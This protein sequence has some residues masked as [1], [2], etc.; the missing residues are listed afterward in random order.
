MKKHK[1]VVSILL[2]I[3]MV[4]TFM[5]TL[6]F[7]DG[8]SV[9]AKAGHSWEKI[10]T[11]T[12]DYEGLKVLEAPTCET[13]GVGEITC[14]IDLNGEACG[15][16]KT[17]WIAPLGHKAGNRVRVKAAD[18]IDAIYPATQAAAVKKAWFDANPDG[19]C[20]AYVY[21]CDNCDQY[22]IEG[23]DG[24]YSRLLALTDIAD[25]DWLAH[26][27]PS[28]TAKCAETFTCKNC[29]VEKRTNLDAVPHTFKESV[30][31][32]H[33][34]GGLGSDG[35]PAEGAK[36]VQITT[37]K[38]SV[39]GLETSATSDNYEGA[40]I[41]HGATTQV[42]VPS[43]VPC[44]IPGRV[45]KVCNDCGMVT[46]TT[47][48]WLADHTYVTYGPYPEGDLLY[49]D[50]R[51]AV[52]GDVKANSKQIYGFAPSAAVA[53]YSYSAVAPANCEQGSWIKVTAKLGNVESS[54]VVD[55]VNIETLIANGSIV[56]I[57]DKYY[58]RNS[59]KEI[60]YVKALEHKF[61]D[62]TKVA[63][64][65]CEERGIEAKV[66]EKCG[67][68]D[69][70][71]VARTGKATGHQFEKT[72]QE[73]TCGAKGFEYEICSVCGKF[74]SYK[75]FGKPVVKFGAKCTMD[76][77]VV[78]T[79]ATPF[80]EGTK[81]LVCSVCGDDGHVYM[82]GGNLKE[83]NVTRTSI[84]K[85]KIAAPKVKAGKKKATVTVKAVEGA[86]K[87]QIKVN[88]KVKKTVTKAGKVT[89]KKLKG[90]KKAKF[91]IVA[92]DAEGTKAASKVKS[93]KIKK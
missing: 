70:N 64:P 32:A 9:A 19:K 27:E 77:W 37:Q 39:C 13:R 91:Q 52:C 15:A 38:C 21:K 65:T 11:V 66:C 51:C 23:G 75:E 18:L 2:A 72:T 48:N 69:H 34:V 22:I 46:E 55:D 89:I 6:A 7:A 82:E 78:E 81:K 8:G 20:Q 68:V 83:G 93:V 29:G 63:D 14:D 73:P 16:V 71:T 67:K 88:G 50:E 86:V 3:M 31:Y 10:D 49:T 60:P 74:G 43:A 41:N 44:K 58:D 56:K 90:G 80:K 85:T 92:F 26:E 5:P 24:V 53:E 30:K 35:K 62:L 4:F 42:I 57:G 84:A 79:K 45:D 17:V 1:S 59:K 12:A 40:A 54:Y 36:Y 25:A 47:T 87:Y 28:G 33:V 76:K 61:G